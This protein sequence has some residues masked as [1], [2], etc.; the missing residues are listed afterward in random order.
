MEHTDKAVVVPL[1]AGWNDVGSWSS[2][3]ECAEQDNDSNV[4]QGYV[5]IDDVTN[6][7]KLTP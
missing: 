7:A 4:L 1:G 6:T 3:W 2:L 5:M